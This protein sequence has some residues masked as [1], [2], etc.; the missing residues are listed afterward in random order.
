MDTVGSDVDGYL[1]ILE[2]LPRRNEDGTGGMH[3]YMPWWNYKQ[4][5]D[6]KMPFARGY[7]IEIGGGRGM[8]AVGTGGGTERILGGGYGV[9]LS[10]ICVRST[11]A[12]SASPDAAK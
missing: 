6:G 5:K 10:A 3:M 1:P 4:Q 8:P 9:S 11:A 7:H 2:D 12:T